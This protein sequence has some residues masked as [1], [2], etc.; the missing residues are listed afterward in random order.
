MMWNGGKEGVIKELDGSSSWILPS[1]QMFS[2]VRMSED[3]GG[4]LTVSK[5]PLGNLHF[6]SLHLCPWNFKL[7]RLELLN[8]R[9]SILFPDCTARFPL[10]YKVWLPPKHSGFLVSRQQH[11][12]RGSWLWSAGRGGILLHSGVKEEYT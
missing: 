11:H 8:P 1:N 2:S 12:A 9:E 3:Q 7:W 6:L 4:R 5:F 10:I